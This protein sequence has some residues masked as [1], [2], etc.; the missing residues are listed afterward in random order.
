MKFGLIF[1]KNRN[2]I[3]DLKKRC[4]YLESIIDISNISNLNELVD[5]FISSCHM[6]LKKIA[7]VLELTEYDDEKNTQIDKLLEYL[8]ILISELEKF[9]NDGEI[10]HKINIKNEES[11]FMKTISFINLKGG[12]GKTTIATNFAYALATSFDVKVLFID[13]DKQ[14]NASDFFNADTEH[15]TITNIMMGDGSAQE[16]IQKTQYPNIDLISADMGLIG[17]HAELI[18][19]SDIDQANILKNALKPILNK[20]QVCI[21]DNPPDINMSVFNSLNIT[22]DIVI[23]TYPDW[24]SLSGVYHMVNQIG[25]SQQLNSHINLKGVLINGYIDNDVTKE[26]VKDLEDHQLPIFNTKIRYATKNAKRHLTKARKNHKSIFEENKM[27]MV[28][29]NIWQFTKEFL[30]VKAE[31]DR[32]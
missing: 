31:L 21:I 29:R 9:Y 14:A 5:T 16:V 2:E 10:I 23:V 22:N 20:Y 26:V 18:K 8:S 13:N 15:G 7:L 17:A 19:N 25:F 6:Q 32:G 12:V 1:M 3:E 27:C 11:F 4:K 28:S 24:D 30:D